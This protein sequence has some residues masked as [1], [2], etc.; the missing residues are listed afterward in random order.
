MKLVEHNLLCAEGEERW[1]VL[2]IQRSRFGAA[3]ILRIP[4]LSRKGLPDFGVL[5]RG[6]V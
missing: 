1:P 2:A 6:K 5:W 4:L 3:G